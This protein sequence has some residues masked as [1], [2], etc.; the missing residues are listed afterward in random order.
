M[1]S[2]T[3]NDTRFKSGE[4]SWSCT[5][6][7]ACE[8]R[9]ELESIDSI[10][11]DD[12]MYLLH[13]IAYHENNQASPSQWLT[14]WDVLLDQ[15]FLR[16]LSDVRDRLPAIA[17]LAAVVHKHTNTRYLFG[18]WESEKFL[19]QLLWHHSGSS[20]RTQISDPRRCPPSNYAPSWSWASCCIEQDHQQFHKS[21][22]KSSKIWKLQ[23]IKIVPST[24]NP[25]GPGTGT[26]QLR[27]IVVRVRHSGSEPNSFRF[28]LKVCAESPHQTS[29]FNQ[30]T[31][32]DPI[33]LTHIDT[34]W[35]KDH[36]T[37]YTDSPE[38]YQSRKLSFFFSTV[39]LK[40][41]EAI[42]FEGLLLEQLDGE[43][44]GLRTYRRL[45]HMGDKFLVPSRSEEGLPWARD[46][47]HDPERRKSIVVTWEYWQTLG[48]WATIAL[49]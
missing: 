6:S 36:R 31:P 47:Y 46:T 43:V 24:S 20:G 33:A 1:T 5:R 22:A 49:V 25:Y 23:D 15:Y 26:L 39:K 29:K 18:L 40:N 4:M 16:R 30:N 28:Y 8:C 32:D 11:E 17:G 12:N 37:D 45:G 35:A 19:D 2:N 7:T 14:L 21:A 44:Q 48:E 10:E 9:P 41:N 34:H 13:G 27:S 38:W 42:S 3:S